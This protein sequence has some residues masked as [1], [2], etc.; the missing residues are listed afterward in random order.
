MKYNNRQNAAR[1]RSNNLTYVIEQGK[2]KGLKIRYNNQWEIIMP[3]NTSY[4]AD[5]EQDMIDFIL[6][7]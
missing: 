7:Y 5:D 2:R 4:R 3:N 1:G 6:E